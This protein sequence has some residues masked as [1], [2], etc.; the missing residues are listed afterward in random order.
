MP[1]IKSAVEL[2]LMRQMKTTL[3]PLNILNPGRVLPL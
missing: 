2:E 1:A 3:D